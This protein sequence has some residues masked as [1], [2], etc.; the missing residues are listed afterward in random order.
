MLNFKYR[1]ILNPFSVRCLD[2]S[3]VDMIR[4]SSYQKRTKQTIAPTICIMLIWVFFFFW[5]KKKSLKII[6]Y[7]TSLRYS[8]LR[9][10]PF[11]TVCVLWRSSRHILD[12]WNSDGLQFS[13][14]SREG[15]THVFVFSLSFVVALTTLR[16][17]AFLLHLL[18]IPSFYEYVILFSL[19]FF[20]IFMFHSNIFNLCFQRTGGC[21]GWNRTGQFICYR[22]KVFFDWSVPADLNDER[23]SMGIWNCEAGA[24]VH[25]TAV[26]G[27][28]RRRRLF[29]SSNS[30]AKGRGVSR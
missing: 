28:G 2:D 4:S 7:N 6:A 30:I 29:P 3:T 15:N 26:N 5:K 9:R 19:F 14:D 20:F 8:P 22:S 21:L 24:F 27:L 18:L 11:F 13:A 12:C 1:A 25:W 16:L 10:P 23:N 17:C